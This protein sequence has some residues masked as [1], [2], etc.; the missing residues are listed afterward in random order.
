MSA[1]DF[2]L[3]NGVRHD[4]SSL[5]IKLDGQSVVGVKSIDYSD[6]LDP[7]KVYGTAA[8]KL[9]HTRGQYDAEASVE[10]WRY[11]ADAF[12]ARLVQRSPGVG[13]YEIVWDIV[14]NILPEGGGS[15]VTDTIRGCRIKKPQRTSSQGNE[16]LAIKLDLA[17][18]YVMWNGIAP[19]TG[20]TL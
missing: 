12:A 9:A 8:Q 19:L 17:P 2:V 14:V 5:D 20:M 6:S 13:L 18:M 1:A 15:I 16:G 3:V 7:G 4:H 11:E 10:L